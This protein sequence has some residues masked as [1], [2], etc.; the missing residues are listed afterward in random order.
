MSGERNAS[1]HAEPPADV[2]QVH[3]DRAGAD[4][5]AAGDLRSLAAAA[6]SE[7]GSPDG[8]DR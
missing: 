8:G 5:E 3:L 6:L 4:V 1:A 2:D 7:P